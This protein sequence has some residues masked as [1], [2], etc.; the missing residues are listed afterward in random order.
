LDVISANACAFGCGSNTPFLT[1]RGKILENTRM[2]PAIAACFMVEVI[3][4]RDYQAGVGRRRF[5]V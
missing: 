4:R 3:E 2:L 1:A 5:G